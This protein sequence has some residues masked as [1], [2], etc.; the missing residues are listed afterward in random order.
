VTSPQEVRT[1]DRSHPRP[2]TIGLTLLPFEDRLGPAHRW[3][4][5]L[6]VA[7]RAEAV[8]FDAVWIP[9]HLLFREEGQEVSGAWEAWSIL[10]GLATTTSRVALGSFVLCTA[11]R[12]P[13]L[14]AKMADTVDEMSGGRLLLGLGTGWSQ[15]DFDAFGFPFDHRY[16]RF[17]EALQIIHELLRTGAV[18][19][20]GT[21]YQARDCELHPRGPR[22][23]GPPIMIGATREKMLRLTARYADLWNVDWRNRPEEFAVYNAAVDAACAQVGRDPAT[24]IRTAGIMVNLPGYPEQPGLM[25]DSAPLSGTL[26]EIA[27]ALRAH[28]RAG[29]AH[30]QILLNSTGVD[31]IEAF[32]PVLEDLDRVPR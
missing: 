17:E 18:D 15:P 30:A 1:M 21:Y 24:L 25:E 10:T 8:G 12:N 14:I 29:V 3:S 13:A 5:L 26:A 23:G 11:W 31:G 19:F 32:A 22:P 4:T 2:L 28:A 27:E 7:Q 6:A 9:D 20:T 16:A